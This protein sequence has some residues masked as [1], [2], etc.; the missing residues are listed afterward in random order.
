MLDFNLLI[1]AFSLREKEIFEFLE[2]PINVSNGLQYLMDR[3]ARDTGSKHDT[4]L[5]VP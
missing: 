3:I 1:P 5:R 2:V 4:L